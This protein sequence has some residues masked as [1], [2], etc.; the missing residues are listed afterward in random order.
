MATLSTARLT[1]VHSAGILY[2]KESGMETTKMTVRVPKRLLEQA[3]EYARRNDTTLTR[4]ITAYLDRMMAKNDPLADAPIVQ[5][6]SGSLSQDATLQEYRQY[7]EDKY[8]RSD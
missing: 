1:A 5:R 7:L 2:G 4:L 6:L 3:K 8:G